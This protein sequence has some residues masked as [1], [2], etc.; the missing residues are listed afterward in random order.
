MKMQLKSASEEDTQKIG[1]AIG[2]QLRGGEVLV[3]ES[4]LG[5]GKTFL[6]RAIVASAGSE[7]VVSS[8][9]FTLSNVY[10]TSKFQIHHYDFY[11]L[12]EPGILA[13]ELQEVTADKANVC[14]IEWP[15]IVLDS[16]EKNN[17]VHVTISRVRDNENSRLLSVDTPSSYEYLFESKELRDFV[18]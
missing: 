18:C 11:R 16:L 3:L 6:T 9:T 13:Q 10:D 7:A 14:I 15:A 5:G 2:S 12:A 1:H 4:D 8:P 17:V